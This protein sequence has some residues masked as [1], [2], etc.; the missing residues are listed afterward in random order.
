MPSSAATVAWS[1]LVVGSSRDC[2]LPTSAAAIRPPR[3]HH[4]RSRLLVVEQTSMVGG[5]TVWPLER[6]REVAAVARAHGLAVHMD[7]ARLMNAVVASGVAA[8]EFARP[9]DSAWIDFTKGL[10]APVGA[11]LAGSKA[12][13]EEA[14][15]WKHQFG[16]AMRQSGIIAA[17][18]LYALENHVERLA[19]D[20]ANARRLAEMLA[21]IPGVAVQPSRIET[22]ILFFDIAGTGAD[23]FQ[24]HDR[25]L[26]QGIRIGAFSASTMRAVTHL[27]VTRA[28]V[29]AAARALGEVLGEARRQRA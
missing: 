24:V 18:C 9:C 11:V 29:E 12:F 28:Q 25:L 6:V 26:A 15:R 13:I 3:R 22:N 20:H 17:G 1:L 7:G 2:S 21:E 27:D 10:G 19:E 16:G 4:P 14:W 8:G 5:G 23:A